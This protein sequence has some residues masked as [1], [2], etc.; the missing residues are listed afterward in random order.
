MNP[1]GVYCIPFLKF[2][3]FKGMPCEV[4]PTSTPKNVLK[5]LRLQLSAN[6]R[7]WREKR[8][9]GKQTASSELIFLYYLRENVILMLSRRWGI[10]PSV[11]T[12]GFCTRELAPLWGNLQRSEMPFPLS[13]PL[14][15]LPEGGR[16]GLPGK[17]TPLGPAQREHLT[18]RVCS[19]AVLFFVFSVVR[20][21]VHSVSQSVR[22][23]VSQSVGWTSK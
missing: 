17:W 5:I 3:P 18:K 22:Q 14:P 9:S 2:G 1:G 23:T 21:S 20:F 16:T 15:L 10:S 8:F 6:M 19:C 7:R 11:A 12:V 4:M 13:L